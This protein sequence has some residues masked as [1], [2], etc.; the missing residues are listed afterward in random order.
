MIYNFGESVLRSGL[1][2]L[3]HSDS[4]SPGVILRASPS[5]KK[6]SW[7]TYVSSSLYKYHR[8]SS[9]WHPH[10]W[11]MIEV[12]SAINIHNMYHALLCDLVA[13]VTAW[14]QPGIWWATFRTKWVY[15]WDITCWYNVYIAYS[16]ID[17]KKLHMI[18]V[19]FRMWQNGEL[20]CHLPKPS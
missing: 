14:F 15:L 20:Y 1:K 18:R 5:S 6:Y 17:W 10:T 12:G 19:S 11:Q 4:W 9:W 8:L 2:K 7:S 3:A 16:C 13:T